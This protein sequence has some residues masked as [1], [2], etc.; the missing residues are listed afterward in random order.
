MFS[1]MFYNVKGELADAKHFASWVDL[2]NMA[3]S[4]VEGRLALCCE[5]REV[6]SWVVEDCVLEEDEMPFPGV[7]NYF[8]S[9]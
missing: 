4:V 8:L 9:K 7:W 3:T 6:K 5:G 2:Y 1:V